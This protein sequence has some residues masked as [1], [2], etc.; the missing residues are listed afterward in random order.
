MDSAEERNSHCRKIR[1]RNF[2][3]FGTVDTEMTLNRSIDKDRLGGVIF[4]VGPNNCGKSNILDAIC[5]IGNPVFEDGDY[6]SFPLEENRRGPEVRLSIYDNGEV[7]PDWESIKEISGGW[8]QDDVHA[9]RVAAYDILNAL[10]DH[11]ISDTRIKAAYIVVNSAPPD[12]MVSTMKKL[13]SDYDIRRSAE[14]YA[15]EDVASFDEALAVLIPE[16][17]DGAAWFQRKYGYPLVPTV[18]RYEQTHRRQADL[19]RSYGDYGDVITRVLLYI[20]DGPAIV[21]K[22]HDEFIRKGTT[23]SLTA[24]EDFINDKLAPLAD[25]FNDLYKS[26]SYSFRFRLMEDLVS[27]EIHQAGVPLDL[28]KQS[29]GF[30][31]FF[32]FFFD[33]LCVRRLYPGDIVVMDEPATNIHAKGQTELAKMIRDFAI[34]KGITFVIST[35][36]P[37][38]VNC[39]HLEELRIL[40]LDETNR[41]HVHDKFTVMDIQ[42]PD[43]LNSILESLTIGR[44]VLFDPNEKTVFVEGITDYNY[45]TAFKLLF[46]IKGITFLPI[47][48]VKDKELIVEKIRTISKNPVIL[49]DG[50]AAGNALYKYAQ[51]SDVEVVRLSDIDRRFYDIESV[52]TASDRRDFGIDEKEWHISSVFKQYIKQNSRFITDRTKAGFRKILDYLMYGGPTEPLE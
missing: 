15:P 26:S 16:E 47:N 23:G 4:V 51:D 25:M 38:L 10:M 27:L 52:F 2:R 36:S 42:N 32:D 3:N 40:N 33:V 12:R 20:D 22:A 49:V 50:D 39:D 30:K 5:H 41:A 43:Q 29:S 46:G 37:F 18:L 6:P 21:N 44:H 7:D 1:I 11:D 9:L 14:S 28:D 31:W 13:M 19:K 17:S 48:G 34:E 8:S 45:L 24:A 35:H